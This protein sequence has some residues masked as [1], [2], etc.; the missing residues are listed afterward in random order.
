[1]LVNL[2]CGSRYHSAWTNIDFL[3]SG[4]DVIQYDLRSGIPLQANSVDVVYHSH[5]LEHFPRHEALAFLKNCFFVLKPGGILRVVV[6]DL[7]TIITEYLLQ[8]KSAKEGNEEASA[9]YDWILLELFDQVARN[10]SGGEMLKHWKQ[11]PLPAEDYIIK[12]LGSEVKDALKEIRIQPVADPQGRPAIHSRIIHRLKKYCLRILGYTYEMA[13]IGKF[14][15]S[16]E[17]HYCMYDEY[18]LRRVL[19]ETGFVGPNRCAA[20]QSNIP[21]FSSYRLDTE[22]DGSVRKPDSLFMEARKPS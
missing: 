6:P 14:R 4:P 13:E 5:V 12:R 8:M 1:M 18:S 11:T 20:D 10:S 2:G 15:K 16:G 3:K 22:L 21:D 17:I 19:L 9:R 7:E